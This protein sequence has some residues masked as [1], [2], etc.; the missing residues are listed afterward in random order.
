VACVTTLL[1]VLGGA[2][3]IL[4]LELPSRGV[5]ADWHR[6]ILPSLFLSVTT[7]TAGFNTVDMAQFSNPTLLVAM[8]LMVVG[9][10]PAGTAGGVKTTTLATLHALIISRARNRQR[11]ELMGRSLPAEVVSKALFTTAAYAAVIV[12]ATLMIQLVEQGSA[13][14]AQVGSL[15]LPHM[16]EVVSALGTVGLSVNLTP[17]LTD[18]SKLVL[19]ACMFAGRVGP[20]LLATSLVG[21]ARRIDYAYPHE[22]IMIG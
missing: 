4:V 6:K 7:R 10:S 11:V 21:S 19:A 18:P 8:L 9:G 17:T 2:A 1:L 20:L 22:R 12:A 5:A 13:P 16:F 15:F 14:H 3:L